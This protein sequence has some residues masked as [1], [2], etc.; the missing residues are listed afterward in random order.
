MDE[1]KLEAS[2]AVLLDRSERLEKLMLGNGQPGLLQRVATLEET[3]RQAAKAGAKAGATTG[4]AATMLGGLVLLIL[5]HF[6]IK[7]G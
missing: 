4:T 7:L 2:I 5:G 3:D 6:G 1:A